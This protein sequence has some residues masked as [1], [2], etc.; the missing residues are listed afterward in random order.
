MMEIWIFCLCIS[1]LFPLG[2][3]YF[4]M[5]LIEEDIRQ[6]NELKNVELMMKG[7]EL[8]IYDDNDNNEEDDEEIQ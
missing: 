2:L 8:G 6:F 5:V 1:I 3:I 4:R 7:I